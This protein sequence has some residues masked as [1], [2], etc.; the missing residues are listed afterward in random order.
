VA[1]R[2]LED[3]PSETPPWLIGVARN[4]LPEQR[5]SEQRRSALDGR[6]TD[7]ARVDQSTERPDAADEL[8]AQVAIRSALSR[9]RPYDRRPRSTD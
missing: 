8:I 2:R 1:W 6:L 5:R 4:I 3:V 9:L 7:E